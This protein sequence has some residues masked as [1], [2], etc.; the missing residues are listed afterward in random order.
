MHKDSLTLIFVGIKLIL[1]QSTCFLG[2]RTVG[3]FLEAGHWIG[4]VDVSTALN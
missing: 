1:L 3:W 4:D 2:G